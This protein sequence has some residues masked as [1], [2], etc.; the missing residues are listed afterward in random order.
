MSLNMIAPADIVEVSKELFKILDDK[1]KKS[2]DD[3]KKFL[4]KTNLSTEDKTKR[5]A[6]F[7]A[8]LYTISIQNGLNNAIQVVIEDKRIDLQ[9]KLNKAQIKLYETQNTTEVQ[10]ELTARQEVE[11]AQEKVKLAQQELELNKSKMWLENA[12][13][14]VGFD[15]A[16]SQ[17]LS[18][19]RTSGA[20]ITQTPKNYTCPVTNQVVSFEHISLAAASATDKTRG[21]KGLQ[22]LQL[23]KQAKSF[24]NHTMTQLGNQVMQ[25]ASSA[26]SE[27]L[28]NIGGL[29]STH[30][31]IIDI[32]TDDAVS[33]GNY[34]SIN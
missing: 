28:T 24:D 20:E 21:V 7:S 33:S 2:K 27:G 1:E 18:E 22:M 11:L 25:L 10:K 3:M 26:I 14:M 4:D 13:A 31:S 34:T 8:N 30:K 16:V 15:A 23:E 29:L 12:K 5:Y 6:E 32:L 17:T 9:D 19:A